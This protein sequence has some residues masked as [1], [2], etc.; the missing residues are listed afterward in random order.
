MA[1]N[2]R[3]VFWCLTIVSVMPAWILCFQAKAMRW[4]SFKPGAGVHNTITIAR[5]ALAVFL[6]VGALVLFAWMHWHHGDTF[7]GV[8]CALGLIM[9]G[10]MTAPTL[11]DVASLIA[12]LEEA[13]KG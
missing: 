5:L 6:N 1:L 4:V 12:A 9:V 2:Q 10:A 8:A 11:G 7:G 13:N 3:L